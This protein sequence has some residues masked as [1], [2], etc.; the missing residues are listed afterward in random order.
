MAGV[1]EVGALV[2]V[3]SVGFDLRE[4]VTIPSLPDDEQWR[5]LEAVRQAM[6]AYFFRFPPA[7]RYRQSA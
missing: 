1:M 6:P 2:D 7:G 4:A 5:A 3:A